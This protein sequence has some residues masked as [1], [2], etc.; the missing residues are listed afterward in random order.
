MKRNLTLI[1]TLAFSF[2]LVFALALQ[3]MATSQDL[4]ELPDD[5]LDPGCS[6]ECCTIVTHCGTT[7]SG[8]YVRRTGIGQ[9]GKPYF[10]YECVYLTPGQTCYQF[11]CNYVAP[12]SCPID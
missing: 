5:P 4:P 10:Y 7:G 11:K 8:S 3:V 2:V 1:L 12:A 9:D 6:W